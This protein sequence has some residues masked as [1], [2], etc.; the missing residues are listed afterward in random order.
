M[1]ERE[2]EGESER[3]RESARE[4]FVLFFEF[5]N[6]TL[7]R[8]KKGKEKK[9]THQTCRTWPPPTAYPL[10]SAITGLGSLRI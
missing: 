7:T 9:N 6:S 1:R 2:R 10:T 4:F 5:S 8:K 3:G